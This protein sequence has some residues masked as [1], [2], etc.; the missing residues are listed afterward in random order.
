LFSLA[1]SHTFDGR[2]V[3]YFQA[4]RS[5][6]HMHCP[7]ASAQNLNTDV[8]LHN[9]DQA[10]EHRSIS[11]AMNEFETT[12][13]SLRGGLGTRQAV[14]DVCTSGNNPAAVDDLTS[15]LLDPAGDLSITAGAL[16][17]LLPKLETLLRYHKFSCRRL[18]TARA[19]PSILACA[20]LASLGSI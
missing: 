11:L 6:I 8:T 12:L 10:C 9:N 17:S 16:A 2:N 20:Q 7:E 4:K 19:P 1:C 14:N 18:P 5:H 15:R 3:E 13:L